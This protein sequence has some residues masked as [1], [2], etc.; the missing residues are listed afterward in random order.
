MHLEVDLQKGVKYHGLEFG[1]QSVPSG[2]A[3]GQHLVLLPWWAGG[4]SVLAGVHGPHQPE[5]PLL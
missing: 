4:E 2:T 1:L 5:M 3:F